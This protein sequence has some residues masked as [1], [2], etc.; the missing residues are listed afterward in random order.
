V[1]SI[2]IRS[3]AAA[4][5]VAVIMGL[6]ACVSFAQDPIDC[7]ETA[8]AS[9]VPA[10]NQISLVLVPSDNFTNFGSLLESLRP[11][12][13]DMLGDQ[14]GEINVVI[15]DGHPE[16]VLKISSDSTGDDGR[17]K[18]KYLAIGV[19]KAFFC[20]VPNKD[21]Q[22]LSP[23]SVEPESD[24]IQALGLAAVPFANNST[25][26]KKI[27]V[28]GNGIQTAGQYSFL[29]TGVPSEGSVASA[30]AKL[31]NASALPDLYGATVSWTGLGQ[32]SGAQPALNEQSLKGL[33]A[34]WLSIIEASNGVA[35]AIVGEGQSGSPAP[36][37]LHVSP[38]Q[39]LPKACVSATLTEKDGFNFERG[40]ANFRDP[41]AAKS[42]AAVIAQEIAKNS[43]CQGTVTVTGYVAAGVNK[44]TYVFG[45]AADAELSRSRAEA[46]K[47]LLVQAGVTVPI[48]A[49]GGG[50]GPEVDWDTNGVYLES[51][52]QLNRKV[53]VIQQ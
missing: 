32:V 17:A 40:T 38:V 16:N 34:F 12:I 21:V 48:V 28:I 15:A 35:G 39:V 23:F 26:A 10:V 42:G 24:L 18:N 49:A 41:V 47:S 25:S 43:N 8:A 13:R 46:F 3:A 14:P 4:L 5:S 33:K 2:A 51:Q 1:R 37:S 29:E 20:V 11:Q 31:K 9:K 22:T 30:V 45:N 36:S 53:T 19:D 52:G 44:D 50:K 27:F 6:T 7:A